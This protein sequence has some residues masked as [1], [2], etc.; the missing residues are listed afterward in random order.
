MLAIVSF[1]FGLHSQR[2]VTTLSPGRAEKASSA[3]AL[4][5]QSSLIKLHVISTTVRANVQCAHWPLRIALEKV[6]VQP[7][8]N[9]AA[10]S[11][12]EVILSKSRLSAQTA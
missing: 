2:V 7:G 10:G 12:L 9:E 1:S 3:Q 11:D 4:M 8:S 6:G 5:I